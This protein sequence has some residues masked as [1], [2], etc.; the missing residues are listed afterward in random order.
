MHDPI[1]YPTTEYRSF[2]V[3]FQRDCC[4]DENRQPNWQI[5]VRCVPDGAQTAVVTFAELV[6]FLADATSLE[7]E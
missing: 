4:D 1:S 5:F 2:L 3:R 6:A 7:S